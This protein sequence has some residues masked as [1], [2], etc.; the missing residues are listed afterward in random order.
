ELAAR[1]F[2]ALAVSL[3]AEVVP[4]LREYER[5]TTTLAN[6]FVQPLMDRYIARIEAEL[7]RR[8]FAGRFY[9]MQ[10]AGG[11]ASPEMAR[12]LPIRLLESGPAGGGLATALFGAASGKRQVLSFDMGGT[13]A[14]A[15]LVEDGRI[16][17]APLMEAAR[18]HRFKRGSGLPIKAPVID[19]IE[20]GAGGGSIAA[21]DEVGLL[22]VGPRSAGADPGPACYARGGAEP[23]VTDANLLLGYYDPGFFLGGR[24]ALD[25]AAAEAALARVGA[26]IGLDAV[27]AAAGIHRLVTE[28]MAAAARIHIVEKGKDPRR[29]AMVGFGGAGP[30]HAA[31]VARILGVRE[32]LIPPASGAASALGFL[33]APLSFEQVRSHPVRLDA[34]R[35][36][37]IISATLQELEQEAR[38]RLVAGGVAAS[39]VV[40]E[41]SADMR[42]EGQMHEINVP[43]PDSAITAASLPAIRDAFA[44]VYAE[45]Y[46][47]VYGG[48]GVQP[49]S[50]RGR[51]RGPL[52]ALWLAQAG[53]DASGPA[54]KG[55]RQAWFD[56]GFVAT[57]VYDRYALAPDMVIA[58]PA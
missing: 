14:K 24:M 36:A 31:E 35:A 41:R 26:K 21:I 40:T 2:P 28:N 11:L 39:D 30:A 44:R 32:V 37:E 29:Y 52:P 27:G 53:A 13:T 34:D 18:V 16:D 58:G 19:M 5:A 9:L 22:R 38:G 46:T 42:L 10:S 1:E 48:V 23:T 4:E 49:I 12:R 50:F 54:R 47:S 33:A 20:I 25:R 45:R 56:G 3:S 6:A 57:P 15:C 43:L 51:C 7:R 17:I 55:T 8:G